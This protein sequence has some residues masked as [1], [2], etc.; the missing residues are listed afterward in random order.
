[1]EYLAKQLYASMQTGI[2]DRPI[3]VPILGMLLRNV[4]FLL[5]VV[6]HCFRRLL[7]PY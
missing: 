5:V 7:P 2:S 1:M 3:Q 6:S 4:F